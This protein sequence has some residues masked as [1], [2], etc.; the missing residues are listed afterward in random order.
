MSIDH[1]I[2]FKNDYNEDSIGKTY[3]SFKDSFKT[4]RKFKSYH[5]ASMASTSRYPDLYGLF[6]KVKNSNPVKDFLDYTCSHY[7]VTQGTMNFYINN[8][9][10][11]I[12]KGDAI[13]ISSLKK[14]GFSGN[15]AL[16]KL[17]N[18]ENIDTNDLTQISRL[19]KPINTLVR[20]YKD[21]KSWGYD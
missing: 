13:W 5:V 4:I 15:G 7:L 1:N 21:K 18:G 11:L 12:Q 3:M 20:S 6:I 9:K 16:M 2:F 19:Y 17:V 10:I 14:H 8:K